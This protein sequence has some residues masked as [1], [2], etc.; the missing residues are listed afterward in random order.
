M[1]ARQVDELKRRLAELEAHHAVGKNAE[2]LKLGDAA[3]AP[4]RAPSAGSRSSP[5][6]SCGLAAPPPTWATTSKS[7]PG[8]KDAFAAALAGRDDKTLKE[9]PVRLAQEYIYKNEMPEFDYWER[10]AAAAVSRGTPEPHL[11][12][13]LEHKRCVALN[14]ARARQ[15]AAALLRGARAEGATSRS[16]SGS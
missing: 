13:F 9:S 11:E 6:S 8:F 10:V 1:Q 14:R 3:A 7:I 2:A 16:T 12:S 4:T 15:G 5:R